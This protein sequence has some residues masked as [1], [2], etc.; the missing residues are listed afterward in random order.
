M[1]TIVLV[2]SIALDRGEVL[3]HSI[4]YMIAESSVVLVCRIILVFGVVLM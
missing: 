2:C 4:P 1:F 3:V